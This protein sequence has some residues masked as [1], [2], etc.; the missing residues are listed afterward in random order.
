MSDRDL[1]LDE[2]AAWH[3]AS[4][5]DDMDW[6]GF[7]AWLEASPDHV[8]AY[9]EVSLGDALLTEHAPKIRAEFADPVADAPPPVRRGWRVW[10]GV[11]MAASIA[12]VVAVPMA[13]RD[14]ARS[15]ATNGTSQSIA[16]ADGSRI[17]LAPHSHLTVKDGET[18]IALEGGAYFSIKHDPSRALV[19]SAGPVQVSDIGTQFDIQAE[20]GSARIGVSEGRVQVSSRQFARPVE[21][22]HGRALAFDAA[23]GSIAIRNINATDVGSWREGRLT[24]ADAPLALVAKDLSRYVGA[25]V[26][27]TGDLGSRRFS[28]TLAIGDGQA[29][30]RDLAQLMG[31]ELHSVDG[32]YRLEPAARR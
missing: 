13:L 19:V 27:V 5:R 28:G 7:T 24:F 22:A 31:L 1:I 32:G 10:G 15:Y 30:L 12:A 8:A 25:K 29:A 26:T 14:D 17:D 23:Q 16:L 2:A 4:A 18:R 3:I 9:D 20:S 21:L 11:A 6:D